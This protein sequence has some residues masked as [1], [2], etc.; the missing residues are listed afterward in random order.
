LISS[1]ISD[2]DKAL[3]C[4][5]MA[6][7]EEQLGREQQAL[8]SYDRGISYERIHSRSFVAEHKAGYL[9]RLGRHQ[10]GLRL[11]EELLLR[12]ALM[13]EEKTRISQNIKLLR[14]Q[15]DPGI[16]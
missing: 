2:L 12:R 11:Y 9:S 7:V 5:N 8:G 4:Y 13:E 3:M 10:E 16:A 6:V 14:E 1:D 15:S